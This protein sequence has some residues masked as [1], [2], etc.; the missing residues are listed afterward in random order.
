[1]GRYSEYDFEDKERVSIWV[2]IVPWQQLPNEYFEEHYGGGDDE[3]FAQFSH[4]FGVGFYDHDFVST[5][6]SEESKPLVNLLGP[7]SYSS[8]FLEPALA[9]ARRRGL[10]KTSFVFLLYDYDYDPEVTKVSRTAYMEFLG[11]FPYDS[12]E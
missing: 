7:C 10:D 2:A 3:P 9:E 6:G 5:N 1:M 11:S 8:S 4:E 12:E